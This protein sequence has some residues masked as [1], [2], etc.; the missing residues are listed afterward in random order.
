LND[1]SLP[2]GYRDSTGFAIRYNTPVGP[3][4]LEMGWKLNMDGARG[5]GPYHIDVAIGTF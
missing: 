4:S 2:F 3:L 5:E 1:F